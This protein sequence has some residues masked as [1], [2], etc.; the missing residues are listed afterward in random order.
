MRCAKCGRDHALL[1]PSFRRPDAV[2]ALPAEERRT[3]VSE[4][5]DMCFIRPG[6]ADALPRFFLRTVLPVR[7][8]DVAD[9]TQWGFWVEIAEADAKLAWDAW[10]DP[11]QSEQ[12]PF[13]GCVANS[14]KGYPDTI[15]LAVRVQLT[16]PGTRPRATFE[17]VVVH[18]LAEECR[19]GVST[20]KVLAWLGERACAD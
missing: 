10:D 14:V 19:G 20:Q 16:G 11:R 4:N 9:H 18:P 15:G 5:D 17:P 1:E 8:T 7:L 3:R 12:P 13:E 6:S 2:I